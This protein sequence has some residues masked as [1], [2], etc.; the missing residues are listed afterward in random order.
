MPPFARSPKQEPSRDLLL[1]LV[2]LFNTEAAHATVEDERE[3]LASEARA[4][5][6]L[7]LQ[8]CAKTRAA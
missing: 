3:R 8:T 5:A 4:I 6:D 2:A 7:A 1:D